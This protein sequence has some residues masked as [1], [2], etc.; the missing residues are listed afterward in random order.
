MSLSY[1]LC[2]TGPVVK[3][4]NATYPNIMAALSGANLSGLATLVRLAGLDEDLSDPDLAVGAQAGCSR[5]A[6]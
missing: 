1:A 5:S 4:Q 6:K 2:M 3:A